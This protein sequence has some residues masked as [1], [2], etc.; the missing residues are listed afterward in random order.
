MRPRQAAA[1]PLL[2]TVSPTRRSRLTGILDAVARRDF[3]YLVA[4]LSL[5]GKG[6]W[7]LAAA[8]VG[9]PSFFLALVVMAL[10]S[11]FGGSAAATRAPSGES[12]A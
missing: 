6:Y 10:V 3:I 1:G 2:T 7:F 4:V 9:T 8:A 11:R 12:A 5:F